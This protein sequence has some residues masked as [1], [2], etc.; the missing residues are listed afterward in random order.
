MEL[1]RIQLEL[2]QPLAKKSKL[3]QQID[4]ALRSIVNRQ[5]NAALL[6]YLTDIAR[7]TN[8]YVT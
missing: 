8:A 3:Y 2:G 6:Q 7:V 1:T 5:D 4:D